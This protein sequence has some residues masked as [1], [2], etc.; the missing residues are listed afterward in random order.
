MQICENSERFKALPLLEVVA[1][2]GTRSMWQKAIYY[3]YWENI[4]RGYEDILSILFVI[5]LFLKV[6][7]CVTVILFVRTFY[8]RKET[9]LH[10]LFEKLADKKYEL[11]VKLNERKKNKRKA[12]WEKD[13]LPRE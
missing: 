10:G 13:E 2:F 12:K 3:P 6:S 1:S 5:R 4:A 9:D 8:V 11:E 7:A